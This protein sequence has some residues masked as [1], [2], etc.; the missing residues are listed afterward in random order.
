MIQQFEP[1]F[2]V[3]DLKDR[4]NEYLGSGGWMTEFKHTAELENAVKE[5]LGVKH[6]FMVNNGTI[7][8]SLAL[9]AVGVKPGDDVLVPDLTMIATSNAVRFIGATP[10]LVDVDPVNLCMNLDSAYRLVT[11]KTK[12]LMYVTLH[13]RS[14]YP[15]KVMDFCSANKL[16]YISDDAQSLGSRY[17][18][19]EKIGRYGD[20]SSFSFSMPKI[21]TTGQGGCLVTNDDKIADK[22]KKLKD[23]GR[24]G[25]GLDIHDEFGVNCKFTEMQ[26][27]VGL[28]QFKDIEAR[29][30]KKRE[31]Y[32]IYDS[33]LRNVPQV[34]LIDTDLNCVTPWFMDV[35]VDN[36][37]DLAKFLLAS[38]I[39]TRNIDGF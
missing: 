29:I 28:S 18:N 26:A 4:F 36:R 12:A 23:F 24:T 19:G 2:D 31:M 22:I 33:I 9:L 39:R 3:R 17:P 10:V 1:S 38:G 11:V 6:C 32:R 34:T 25:G 20:V 13:G 16:A 7:S 8:L 14:D 30:L 35:Y 27:I 21:I 15:T 37:N 5:F